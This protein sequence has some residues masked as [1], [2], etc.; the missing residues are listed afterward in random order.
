MLLAPRISEDLFFFSRVSCA[1]RL[2]WRTK[3]EKAT[4]SLRNTERS[5][6]QQWT[7]YLAYVLWLRSF[8]SDFQFNWGENGQHLNIIAIRGGV[9]TSLKTS[10]A[11]YIQFSP[12]AH[13][14]ATARKKPS[15]KYDFYFTLELRIYLKLSS[16]S[17]SIKTCP[18]WIRYECVQFQI[19]KGKVCIRARR[20]IR[21]E[22]IPVSVTW[23]G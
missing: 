11:Y 3:R 8:F 20:L 9:F 18:S 1:S 23:S 21:P 12:Y 6:I 4:R 7:W 22:L 15:K 5:I 2:N 13:T 19:E 14:T 17:V 16:V 10:N